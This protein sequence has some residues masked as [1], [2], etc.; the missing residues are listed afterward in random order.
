MVTIEGFAR[1]WDD[2]IGSLEA[3]DLARLGRDSPAGAAPVRGLAGTR[4]YRP[5]R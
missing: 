1:R 4:R 5:I 2:R 3:G